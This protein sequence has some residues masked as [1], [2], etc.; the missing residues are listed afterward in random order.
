[1]RYIKEYKIFENLSNPVSINQFVSQIGIPDPK[2]QRIIEWWNENRSHIKIHYFEFS[3]PQPIAGVFL[4]IDE[5]AINRRLPMPPHMKLFL[6]LHESAHCDQHR[7]G[8]FM[9]HYYNTV[10]EGDKDS[11]LQ[12]YAQL[13]REANDF[14]VNS[15]RQIGFD[16]EMTR[17]EMMIRG[18]ERAG[19]MVYNMMRSDIERFRPVDFIDLLK[20]QIL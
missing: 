5:I 6:A 18:N 13:E 12:G 3:S 4:G 8:R 9:E 14:A 7:Q 20:K 15:M 11:F 19:Q 2:R 1:M 10:V 17:E 16:N